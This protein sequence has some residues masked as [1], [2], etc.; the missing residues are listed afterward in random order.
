[1]LL[2]VSNALK[3]A[4]IGS[5]TSLLGGVI[6]ASALFAA[7]YLFVRLTY[8][9]AIVRRCSADPPREERRSRRRSLGWLARASEAYEPW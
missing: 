4:M 3:N 6:G 8:R 5:D 2:L 9:S 1:V 7:T